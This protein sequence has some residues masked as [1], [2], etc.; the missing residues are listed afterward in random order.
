MA[1]ETAQHRADT[2]QVKADAKADA[3]ADKNLSPEQKADK[4]LQE[5]NKKKREERTKLVDETFVKLQSEAEKS[6]D[7]R[8][9]QEVIKEVADRAAKTQIIA[10]GAQMGTPPPEETPVYPLVAPPLPDGTPVA[11]ITQVE[12][13][14]D[15]KPAPKEHAVSGKK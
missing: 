14:E 15:D 12:K 4:E 1:V 6:G 9:T 2:A 10:A 3:E 11:H 5:A 8:A 7:P 13:K